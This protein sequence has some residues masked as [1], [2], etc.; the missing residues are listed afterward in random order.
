MLPMLNK[1]HILFYRSI[2]KTTLIS[3]HY[4]VHYTSFPL[5]GCIFE[6]Q[7]FDAPAN[8]CIFEDHTVKSSLLI[9]YRNNYYIIYVW[10]YMCDCVCIKYIGLQ[11]HYN[12]KTKT[13]RLLT[14]RHMM[15]VAPFYSLTTTHSLTAKDYMIKL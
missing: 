4:V 9:F 15:R 10:W 13:H 14:E 11:H 8:G 7:M 5:K 2:K 3:T 6:S 1:W 12:P